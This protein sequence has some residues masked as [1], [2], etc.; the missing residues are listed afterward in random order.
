MPD[1]NS[2]R[3]VSRFRVSWPAVEAVLKKTFKVNILGM[4][5]KTINIKTPSA[6]ADWRMRQA[7]QIEVDAVESR[8]VD[9]PKA[10][11][12]YFNSTNRDATKCLFRVPK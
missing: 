5:W 12:L 6:S 7:L 4:Q 2:F 9:L 3:T 1:L 10:M 11:S 8:E